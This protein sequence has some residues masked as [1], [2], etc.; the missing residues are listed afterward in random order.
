MVVLGNS[1][2]LQCLQ[3]GSWSE[4]SWLS[5]EPAL[6]AAGCL[7]FLRQLFQGKCK[8]GSIDVGHM[9]WWFPSPSWFK[10]QKFLSWEKGFSLPGV[11]DFW[12]S[13]SSW[14]SRAKLFDTDFRYSFAWIN[15]SKTWEKKNLLAALNKIFTRCWSEESKPVWNESLSVGHNPFQA[16]PSHL[17]KG[18]QCKICSYRTRSTAAL[19]L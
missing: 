4:C 7:I 18:D 12:D 13:H 8:G 1:S 15:L 19:C 17:A 11:A 2:Q 9:L 10:T 14:C 16:H 5:S 3:Q 6:R